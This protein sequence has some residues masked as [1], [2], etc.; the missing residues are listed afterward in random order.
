MKPCKFTINKA[1]LALFAVM[2]AM[3]PAA[4]LAEK[5]PDFLGKVQLHNFDGFEPTADGAGVTLYRLPAEVRSALSPE[6]ARQITHAR[7]SEIRFVLNEG[8]KLE[9]V[10]I[11]LKSNRNSRVMYYRG[12]ELVGVIKGLPKKKD[13]EV[14]IPPSMRETYQVT[15]DDQAIEYSLKP[16]AIKPAPMTESSGDESAPRQF[17]EQ[18]HRILFNSGVITLTGIEGDI[19]PPREDEVPPVLV[20]YGTSISMGAAATS[21]DLSFTALTAR[22]LGMSLRNLGVSGN[23][24]CEPEMA[25]Y[26]AEQPGD[27]FLFEISVNMVGNGFEV[28]EF[29]KRAAYLIDAVAKAHPKTSVVC[30]SILPYGQ[31]QSEN[32]AAR[33]REFRMALEEICRSTPHKNV[34]FVDGT[35]LLSFEGL[36]KDNIH[37]TDAGHAEIAGKLVTQIQQILNKE[38]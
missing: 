27:L 15:K 35:K 25:D 2:A 38:K 34:H 5:L 26:L 14:Y 4:L 3:L 29:R 36:A 31:D 17:S 12:D 22:A 10:V 32:T 30:I 13:A 19:R 11:A 23:A 7:S 8:A 1:T 20:S 28:D 37:P 16:A 24:F 33:P 9:D 6:G 18:V 21:P